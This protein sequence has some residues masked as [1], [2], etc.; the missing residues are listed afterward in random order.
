MRKMIILALLLGACGHRDDG[1][2]TAAKTWYGYC[3]KTTPDD[4][5]RERQ[6]Y[7]LAATDRQL[8]QND[9]SILAQQQA[10]TAAWGRWA[11]ARRW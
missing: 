6:Q 2:Y 7:M 5:E 4:C 3:L 11:M 8:R 10:T 1:G 9:Q